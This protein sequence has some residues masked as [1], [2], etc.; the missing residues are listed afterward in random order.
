MH[1]TKIEPNYDQCCWK[2]KSSRASL[3]YKDI[4][5]GAIPNFL[6]EQVFV[7][8]LVIHGNRYC[9]FGGFFSMQLLAFS[10]QM[11]HILLELVLCLKQPSGQRASDCVYMSD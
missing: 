5:G 3:T 11:V 6:P 1:T 4:S 9:V 2:E 10:M 8:S 7:P